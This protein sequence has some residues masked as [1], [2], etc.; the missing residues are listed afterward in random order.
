MNGAAANLIHKDD[1]VIIISYAMYDE[2]ELPNH[3]P[4]IVHVDTKN[5][6]LIESGV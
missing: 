3:S 2:S 4:K 6:H 5:Q 1:L